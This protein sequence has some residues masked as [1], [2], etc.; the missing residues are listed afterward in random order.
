M[1]YKRV[2]SVVIA[3]VVMSG[4]A[5]SPI[6]ADQSPV[7]EQFVLRESPGD[8]YYRLTT[9]ASDDP[10]CAGVFK[11]SYYQ[12]RGEFRVYFGLQPGML[13]S[14]PSSI[15]G[16]VYGQ[17]VE[18]GTKVIVRDAQFGFAHEKFSSQIANFVRTGSCS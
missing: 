13:S 2:L 3:G 17:R 14:A 10:V 5:K 4:C 18:G 11:S 15:L 6:D 1:V 8:L 9:Q 16:G 7:Y 12:E